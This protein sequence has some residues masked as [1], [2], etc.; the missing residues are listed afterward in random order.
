MGVREERERE[1]V[2]VF[3]CADGDPE[4]GVMMTGGEKVEERSE[5]LEAWRRS[6]CERR[7]EISRDR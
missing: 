7:W 6:M 3:L 2:Q 4:E 5:V 1:L